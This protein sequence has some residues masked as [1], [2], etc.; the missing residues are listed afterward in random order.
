MSAIIFFASWLLYALE[1]G[2]ADKGSIR[3][4]I[5]REFLGA[6]WVQVNGRYIEEEDAHGEYSFDSIGGDQVWQV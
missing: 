1:A 6:G 3:A 2:R 5:A 4:Q